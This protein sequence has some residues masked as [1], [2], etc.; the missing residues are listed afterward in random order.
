MKFGH[1]VFIFP[2]VRMSIPLPIRTS[3]KQSGFSVYFQPQTIIISPSPFYFSNL[4]MNIL[5]FYY[6]LY[7]IENISNAFTA[8]CLSCMASNSNC[9]FLL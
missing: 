3:V 7:D 4:L 5:I 2:F 6:D 9:S 8:H 1:K